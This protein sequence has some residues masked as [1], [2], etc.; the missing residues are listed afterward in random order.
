MICTVRVPRA[1]VN[2]CVACCAATI[3]LAVAAG[4]VWAQKQ[5]DVDKEHALIGVGSQDASAKVPQDPAMQ[6]YPKAGLG[7]FIHWGISSVDGKHELSW[8][9]MKNCPW[10]EP[11]MTPEAYFKLADRFNPQAYDPEKWLRAAKD[12]GFGYAVLTTRHHDGYALWPSAYG[13]FSTRTK[14]GGRD[15]VRPYVEA[16]R[17]VGLKVGFYYSPPD[18]YFNRQYTS[19]YRDSKGTP[20]SPHLGLKHEVV[21]LP[22]RPAEFE[23]R[24]VDYVNGQ[25][26]ELL[27]NYGKIDLLWF[28]GSAGPKV[29]SQEKI[30]AMQ[31]GIVIDD[32]QHRKGDFNTHF[33]NRLPRRRPEGWW[34]H[35][36]CMSGRWGYRDSEDCKPA[37][38]LLTRLVTCRAWGGNVLANF[39]PRPT[40]EMP[41]SV[42]RCMADI[43]AWMDTHRESVIDV[44]PGPYPE[45][46]NVPVTVR[47]DTWYLHLLPRGRRHQTHDDS[48]VL[49]GVG[50]PKQVKMLGTN[51]ALD[52]RLEGDSL[53]IDVPRKLRTPLVDVI[54]VRW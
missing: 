11:A 26:T 32:R 52:A 8:G 37:A 54:A 38:V 10:L 16:C 53:T 4:S 31:P 22:K 15:L 21:Q 48:V 19:F 12:A 18:W 39:A 34:E 17:K 42:Y 40:G 44:Q 45:Q 9:M 50:K 33:E 14:M 23:A 6:W 29:L 51:Q 25:I 35:C 7:M 3:F 13:D 2:R 28:D 27:T 46:S 36:F 5:G 49:T 24:Y 1:R 20:E 30:R 41:D 43:K 47:G